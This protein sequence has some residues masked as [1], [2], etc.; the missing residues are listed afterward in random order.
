MPIPFPIPASLPRCTVGEWT[1]GSRQ[2]YRE[3]FANVTV[4]AEFTGPDDHSFQVRP[5]KRIQRR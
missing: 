3:P 1:I 2:S 5:A 4:D